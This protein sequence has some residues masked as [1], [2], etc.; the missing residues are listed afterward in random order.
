M[1]SILKDK[2]NLILDLD[3]TLVHTTI[4]TGELRFYNSNFITYRF[5][6]NGIKYITYYRPHLFD[7][8]NESFKK[9]NMYI[10][11][12]GTKLYANKIIKEICEKLGFN[13]FIK[14]Y[15]REDFPNRK[16][17]LQDCDITNFNVVII[18]DNL[19]VWSANSL[20]NIINIKPFYGPKVLYSEQDNKLQEI[21]ILLDNIKKIFDEYYFVDINADKIL[22]E[23][24]NSLKTEN[25]LSKDSP[26]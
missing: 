7:F 19:S 21:M 26:A 24:I 23:Q 6:D 13:P 4:D 8:L 11:T 10:Y 22:I 18:D 20:N 1:D 9:F 2:I 14:I 17:F 15:T 12:F 5:E 25:S 3:E 16:K